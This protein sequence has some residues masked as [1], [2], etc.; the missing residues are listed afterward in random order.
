MKKETSVK[1]L[2]GEVMVEPETLVDYGDRGNF[3]SIRLNLYDS[4]T[5]FRAP[6]L[7]LNSLE[8]IA[9][10]RD[11]LT[12]VIRNEVSDKKRKFE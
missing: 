8:T 9:K 7:S 10:L 12:G 2:L 4:K 11:Y 5:D 3:R 6:A 1:G